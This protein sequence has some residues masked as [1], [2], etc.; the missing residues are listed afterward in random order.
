MG[1]TQ[2]KTILRQRRYQE[3]W[4]DGRLH[5]CRKGLENDIIHDDPLM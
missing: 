4:A 5:Y 2:M 3:E 1:E